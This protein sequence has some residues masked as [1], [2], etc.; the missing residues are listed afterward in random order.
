[1]TRRKEGVEPRGHRSGGSDH[2]RRKS[3]WEPEEGSPLLGSGGEG[4]AAGVQSEDND[5][6][7]R[8]LQRGKWVKKMDGPSCSDWIL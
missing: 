7:R 3:P 1:M 2:Q 6:D 8:S 4:G 5:N